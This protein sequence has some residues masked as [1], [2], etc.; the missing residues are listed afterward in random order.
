MTRLR[1]PSLAL[2][3]L[4]GA[5]ALAPASLSQTRSVTGTDE[6]FAR[7]AYVSGT[8]SFRADEDVGRQQPAFIGFPMVSGDRL[9][10]EEDSR[11]E[12][13][14]SGVTIYLAPGS[15]L[16]AVNLA[17]DERRLWLHSGS[18]SVRIERLDVDS[19]EVD[20]PNASVTLGRAGDYRIDVGAHGSTR[21]LVSRG[22]AYV[23]AGRCERPLAA[24]SLMLIDGQ[25]TP[26]I[27]VAA[28]PLPDAWDEWVVGRVRGAVRE[29]GRALVGR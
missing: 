10:T 21:V 13:A 2:L 8:T 9:T 7:V 19:V 17:E 23:A 26:T 25:R 5:V 3:S 1:R 12:L 28:I 15:D 14:L 24:G 16:G 29:P 18:V 27:D 4:L 11:L 22:H 20:T 6:P